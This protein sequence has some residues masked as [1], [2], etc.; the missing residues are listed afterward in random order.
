M[1]PILL[2]KV[3][4]TFILF[5]NS[6]FLANLLKFH[7]AE[8]SC[9]QFDSEMTK[10]KKSGTWQMT[11]G[12]SLA[13]LNPVCQ[14]W[15]SSSLRSPSLSLQGMEITL[16]SGVGDW[17]A[18]VIMVITVAVL[19]LPLFVSLLCCYCGGKTG[20]RKCFDL[21]QECELFKT[22]WTVRLVGRHRLE[23]VE[24]GKGLTLAWEPL[25]HLQNSEWL[26]SWD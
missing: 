13:Q 24:R 26:A 15:E 19:W 11:F 20:I 9:A 3:S 6:T 25:L 5:A 7:N 17:G 10:R 4:V 14:L 16:Y 21:L 23:A 8:S 1:C 18:F 12:E 2:H 22:K